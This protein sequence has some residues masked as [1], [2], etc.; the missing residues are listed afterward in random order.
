MSNLKRQLS[1]WIS[2]HGLATSRPLVSQ[3]ASKIYL[4]LY[5]C[6]LCSIVFGSLFLPFTIAFFIA[7]NQITAR[8]DRPQT[9]RN[10]QKPR[11]AHTLTPVWL[12]CYLRGQVCYTDYWRQNG[13]HVTVSKKRTQINI[14][15][16]NRRWMWT[17]DCSFY[18]WIIE[19]TNGIIF[20]INEFISS[21]AT[22]TL[23][24]L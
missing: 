18:E 7:F 21:L 23:D 13:V 24:L 4:F 12:S 5:S 9:Q 19:S 22:K 8:I 16:L 10:W 14:R 1:N 11:I 17:L 20:S 6:L 3:L 2:I 15:L